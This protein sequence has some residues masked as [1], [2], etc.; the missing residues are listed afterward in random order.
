MP[1]KNPFYQF[2]PDGVSFISEK[3]SNDRMMY[4][5]LCGINAEGI[6]SSVTPFLAGDIKID[7]ERFLTKPASREDLRN[8]L[9]NFYVFID[10]HRIGSLTEDVSVQNSFIEAGLLWYKSKKRNNQIGIEFESINFVP[11]TGETVELMSTTVKNV[12]KENL[13]IVPTFAMPIF[14]RPLANKHDHEHVSALFHRI[15]QLPE[16]VF[17]N[18]TM[19]FDEE[20]HKNNPSVYYVCGIT[21]EGKM[22]AGTFPTAMSFLGE[23]GTM[24]APE[25]VCKNI[26]PAKLSDEAL[27]GHEAMGALRFNA[28]TLMPGESRQYFMAMGIGASLSEAQKVFNT[29][30]SREKF[31]KAWQANKSYWLEKS[32]TVSFR[33]GDHDHDAWMRWVS[34]QPV[35]RRIFG[36]SFLPDHDYGK[37]G[38]GWRDIWQDLLSLI[39]IEPESI[40]EVLINNFKGVRIDG[41]NATIIG[42]KPGEFLADRNAITRVWMDHG[43]WPLTTLLLYIH[44]TGDFD[45]LFE[46]IPYFKDQQLSRAARQDPVWTPASDRRLKDVKGKIYQGTVIEHTLTQHLVQ[47]YNAGEHNHIRLENADWNDGLDMAPERGESVAFTSFYGGNLLELAD[48]LETL[49][50][51]KGMTQLTLAKETFIL[52]DTSSKKKINYDNVTAKRKLLFEKYFKAV[53]PKISGQKVKVKVKNVIED[54]RRKGRWIFEHIR[55]TEKM[56]VNDGNQKNIWFNGYYDNKGKRLEGR[57]GNRIGMTLTGQVFTIMSGLADQEEIR[58]MTAAVSTY[59]K[60]KKWGGLRL[61]T[62]FEMSYSLDLGRAFGFAYGNKEN[63]AFFSHM[64]VMYAYALYKRGFAKQGYDVLES[65]YKMCL[66]TEHSKIYPGIPE[67]FDSEGRGMY[68]YLTG[69]ASWLVLTK[70]TQV[71]G[72]RG[73]YGDLILDPKLVREEFDKQGQAQVQCRFAGKELKIIYVNKK[74]LGPGTYKIAQ[75]KL[76]QN[77]IRFE[78]LPSGEVALLRRS[79]TRWTSLNELEVILDS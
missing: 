4:F 5:P 67:Y 25:A 7:K 20:G 11:V 24:H 10:D 30:N 8:D 13:K 46:E 35:L 51:K 47:F 17:V 52:L 38:K 2:Q 77:P 56:T 23:T 44:Q 62:E 41:T 27:E 72:V 34:I 22:P 59:L 58:S 15:K 49:A 36:C 71:F 33:T 32:T 50:L 43:A 18:P 6:K 14:G 1:T 64:N 39:L 16:G 55:K 63:G 69:S 68:H 74:M 53:E 78:V 73:R 70:L 66:D 45:I 9:R 12:S 28:T 57:K 75:I 19:I 60:D 79:L 48:L 31:N 21:D 54:L 37:G 29:F 26:S 76:N 61:N 3:T 40:R 42:E 65:I